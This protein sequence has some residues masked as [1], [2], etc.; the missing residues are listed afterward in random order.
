MPVLNGKS[1][2][3]VPVP[4]ANG[5]TAYEW[6]RDSEQLHI[7]KENGLDCCLCIR[8]MILLTNNVR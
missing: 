4:A 1:Y 8:I 2:F 6:A 3:H 5:F 7:V